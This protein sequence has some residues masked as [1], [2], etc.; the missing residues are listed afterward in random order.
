MLI[1]EGVW[2][3]LENCVIKGW[4]EEEILVGGFPC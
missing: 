2:R 4:R 1:V 3:G